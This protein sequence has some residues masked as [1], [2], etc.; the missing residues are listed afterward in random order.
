MSWSSRAVKCVST[1]AS[2]STCPS[3]FFTAR[4]NNYADGLFGT[5]TPMPAQLNAEDHE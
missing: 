4:I 1:T 2:H 5:L 3:L